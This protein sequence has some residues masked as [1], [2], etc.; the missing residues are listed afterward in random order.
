MSA[1]VKRAFGLWIASQVPGLKV[2]ADEIANRRKKSYP[3]CTLTELTHS[4]TWLGTG[5]RDLVTRNEETGFVETS[6]KL[7]REERVFRLLVKAP[8]TKADGSGQSKVDAILNQLER[9]IKQTSMTW[10]QVQIEDTEAETPEIFYIDRMM[11]EGQAA[12]APDVSGEPFLYRGAL[13]V[14]I[15]RTIALEKPVDG[16]IERIHL[17]EN[18]G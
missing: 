14:R 2:R 12:V 1:S 5:R 8:D 7:A 13:S 10:E 6:G 15:A 4:L 3:V 11:P 17:E 18:G 9:L 16:V